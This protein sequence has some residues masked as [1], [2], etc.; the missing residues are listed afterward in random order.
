MNSS[1]V[2]VGKHYH[3][4]FNGVWNTDFTG[5]YVVIGY[6]APDT[7]TLIDKS[8]SIFKIYFNDLGLTREKYDLYIKSSSI[9]YIANKI[10][11]KS[12]IEVNDKEQVYLPAPLIDFAKSYEFL[13]GTKFDFT[14][15]TGSKYFE[16]ILDKQAFES[17]TKSDVKDAI[18]RMDD[19]SGEN[20]SVEISDSEVLTTKEEQDVISEARTRA[21]NN[22]NAS[23]QQYQTN[24]EAAERNLFEMMNET[25]IEKDKY[26]TLATTLKN[27]INEVEALRVSNLS[28]ST[29]L[30]NVKK[31]MIQQ[32]TLIIS[33]EIPVS[34]LGET[35]NAAFENL[36]SL[37]KEQSNIDSSE[38]Q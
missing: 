23:R 22:R 27:K 32:L 12:P 21:M 5:D 9:V 10:T 30:N 6:A 1:S 36:Y 28:E 26:T 19:Y 7:V 16:N 8:T 34:S 25:K 4:V 17:K 31:I 33:G 3:I 35:G 29:I 20:I 2:E 24:I 37:A 13:Q 11:S 15:H 18:E 38:N 14:I